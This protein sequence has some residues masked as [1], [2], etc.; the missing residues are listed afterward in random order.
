MKLLTV[1]LIDEDT[2]DTLTI[3][4]TP[5]LILTSHSIETPSPNVEKVSVPGRNGDLDL[6]STLGDIT[7]GNRTVTL[8]VTS[9]GTQ[10]G[11]FSEDTDILLAYFHGKMVRVIFSD[12]PTLYFYGRC[13][14]SSY[15]VKKGLG[16]W[17]F[18]IDCEPYRYLVSND[19]PSILSWNDIE[20]DNENNDVIA[21]VLDV[22]GE[23]ELVLYNTAMPSTPTFTVDSDMTITYDGVEYTLK[24]GENTVKSIVLRK[25]DNVIGVK[26]KGTIKADFKRGV[27]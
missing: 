2:G 12:E 10:R 14:V 24:T 17:V 5:E 15:G 6:T 11:Y 18:S 9:N 20:F 26:G 19:Q 22:D 13:T 21:D 27:L 7:F 1:T 23:G 25:G 16:E 4:N 8:S 3:G